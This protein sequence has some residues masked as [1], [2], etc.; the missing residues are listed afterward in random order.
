MREKSVSA[1]TQTYSA[2]VRA[3]YARWPLRRGKRLPVRARPLFKPSVPDWIEVE[4][5]IVMMLDPEDYISIEILETGRWEPQSWAAIRQHLPVGGTFVDVGAH[6]GYY[7]LKAAKTVG[8]TGRVIAVEANPDTVRIL[9]GNVEASGANAI[10]VHPVAC[11]DSGNVLEFFGSMRSNTGKASLCRDNALQ[12]GSV[13][14]VCRVCAQPLDAIV[15][16][17][18][19]SRIDVVKIDVEGA[20][21]LVLKGARQAL[22]R[23]SP[24][25]M[26]E[27]N[28]TLLQS[29]GTSTAEVG[30]FLQSLGYLPRYPV[31]DNMVFAK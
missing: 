23:F 26:V 17:N 19:L 14:A 20:E 25:L 24:V 31:E 11:S 21:L 22:T 7:S 4:P 30:E 27:L 15:E 13:G 28:D 2:V 1:Y 18:G 8:P 29:M 3:W 6:I 12:S 16:E 9:R 10:A 5:G